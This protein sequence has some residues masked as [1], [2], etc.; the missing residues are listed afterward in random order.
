VNAKNTPAQ[1]AQKARHFWRNGASV[2]AA[3]ARQ[4]PSTFNMLAALPRAGE[5]PPW[6]GAYSWDFH[7]P[8]WYA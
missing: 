8:A 3:D 5:T 2:G 7:A 4:H 6:P 1:P